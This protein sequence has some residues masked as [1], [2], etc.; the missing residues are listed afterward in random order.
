[1]EQIQVVRLGVSYQE[2]RH[3]F[4]VKTTTNVFL[5]KQR[6]TSVES[7]LEYPTCEFPYE[8]IYI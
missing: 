3:V 5:I 6:C 1:M 2:E 4:A 7:K 8:L